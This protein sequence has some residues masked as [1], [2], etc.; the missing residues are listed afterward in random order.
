MIDCANL[1]SGDETDDLLI[2]SMQRE[3]A[4]LKDRLA[5]ADGDRHALI[6]ALSVLSQENAAIEAAKGGR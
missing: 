4:A 2:A 5:K 6:R 3:I 1:L